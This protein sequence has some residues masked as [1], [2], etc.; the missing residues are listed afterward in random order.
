MET[1]NADT[2][3]TDGTVSATA[4]IKGKAGSLDLSAR[5]NVDELR[6]PLYAGVGAGDFAVEKLREIPNLSARR[7][8]GLQGT[9][10]EIP[11]QVR[12]SFTEFQ[13]RATTIYADLAQRGERLVTS[14]RNNPAAQ[15]AEDQARAALANA[16]QAG[17]NATR[18]VRSAGKAVE[19]EARGA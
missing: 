14:I 17:V 1:T 8:K 19:Q 2:S 12:T 9:W 13:G 10:R 4:D 5:L 3:A 6:K 16:K 18:S 11:A 7:V 15:A